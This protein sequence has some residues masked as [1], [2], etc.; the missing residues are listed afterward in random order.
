[1]SSPSQAAV[2]RSFG[3]LRQS[4][5]RSTIPSNILAFQADLEERIA[6]YNKQLTEEDPAKQVNDLPVLDVPKLNPVFEDFCKDGENHF[7]K[8][9]ANAEQYQS[10]ISDY[11][12]MKEKTNAELQILEANRVGVDKDINKIVTQT[13]GHVGLAMPKLYDPKK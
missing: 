10:A 6:N 13:A 9:E 4:F 8:H 1:M 2:L 5:A 12:Y 7:K 11:L 3:L